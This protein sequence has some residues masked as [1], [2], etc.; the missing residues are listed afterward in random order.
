[1]FLQRM[2][3]D[4]R[5]VALNR[6]Q[7]MTGGRVSISKTSNFML[8]ESLNFMNISG[9]ACVRLWNWLER[10]KIH[11]FNPQMLILHDELELPLGDIKYRPESFKVNGHNGLRDI[12]DKISFPTAR[13]AIGIDRPNTKNS[14]VVA[15]YVLSPFTREQQQVLFDEAYPQ[16]VELLMDIQ[17]RGHL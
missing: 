13:I 17:E 3:K 10:T 14:K 5:M 15:D 7:Q 12:K 11:D 2:Q 16:A 1:M 8:F 9:D 6:H 4:F